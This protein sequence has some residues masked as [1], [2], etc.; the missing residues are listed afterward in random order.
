M[1]TRHLHNGAGDQGVAEVRAGRDGDQVGPGPLL[2]VDGRDE[3]VQ[4]VRV[5]LVLAEAHHVDIDLLLLQLLGQFHNLFLVSLNWRPE[6]KFNLNTHK[7]C[8][9][10]LQLTQQKRQSWSCGSCPVCV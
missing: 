4:D 1:K 5:D 3:L 2:A 9:T 8:L 7:H 10:R 6:Q